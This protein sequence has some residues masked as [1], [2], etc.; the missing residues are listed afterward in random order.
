MGGRTV[1]LMRSLHFGFGFSLIKILTCCQ[2]ML[3]YSVWILTKL[4]LCRPSLNGSQQRI[5]E[6][7]KEVGGNADA[8]KS[9][10]T[11]VT[12][13]P[14]S[15]LFD[16][17]LFIYFWFWPLEWSVDIEVAGEG[18]WGGHTEATRRSLWCAREKF[19][20]NGCLWRSF[21]DV[22]KHVHNGLD[23]IIVYVYSLLALIPGAFFLPQVRILCQP[24]IGL[25]R[26]CTNNTFHHCPAIKRTTI[27]LCFLPFVCNCKP[28]CNRMSL[29]TSSRKDL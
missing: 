26:A 18:G 19:F 5:I 8:P 1:R 23:Q 28:Y 15:E 3:R 24:M 14:A 7:S 16:L 11:V 17:F 21:A 10:F 22:L 2:H 6:T 27:I 25:Q 20:Q 29:C 12:A 9:K 4:P 13:P